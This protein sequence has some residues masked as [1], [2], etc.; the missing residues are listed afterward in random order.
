MIISTSFGECIFSVGL[1][2]KIRKGG[3]KCQK[4]TKLNRDE[5]YT[6][7]CR[8]HQKT[9]NQ[10]EGAKP[11]RWGRP[12]TPSGRPAPHREIWP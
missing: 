10:S 7:D 2:Q 4:G 12:A 1:F 5:I 8:R 6:R 3:L 9:P 11:T